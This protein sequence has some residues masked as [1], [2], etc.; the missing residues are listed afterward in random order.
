M[1]DLLFAEQ[2]LF[3]GPIAATLS[4]KEIGSLSQ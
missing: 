4:R 1:N 2:K 3:T